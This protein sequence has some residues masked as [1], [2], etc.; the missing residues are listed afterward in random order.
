MVVAKN[1]A[2]QE[3]LNEGYRISKLFDLVND[4]WHIIKAVHLL[5]H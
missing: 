5:T 1:V 4:H 2:K 3:S